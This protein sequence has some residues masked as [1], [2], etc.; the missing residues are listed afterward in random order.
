MKIQEWVDSLQIPEGLEYV[1]LGWPD[2]EHGITPGA[3]Q[4]YCDELAGDSAE[5][6]IEYAPMPWESW[7]EEQRESVAEGLEFSHYRC[8]VCCSPAG[9]R[10]Y[11]TAWNK[12]M[13]DYKP[14]EVCGDC[15]AYFATGDV[16]EEL[17]AD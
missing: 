16:P 9:A 12:D 4:D 17:E 8:D 14:L 7:R 15:Y 1:T 10:H 3:W 5:F 2:E 11:V 13:T 6:G